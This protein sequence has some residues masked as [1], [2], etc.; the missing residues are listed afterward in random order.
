MCAISVAVSATEQFVNRSL[1]HAKENNEL[2]DDWTDIVQISPKF[3]ST[4]VA[5]TAEG[6]MVYGNVHNSK[7]Y[8]GNDE[9]LSGIDSWNDIVSFDYCIM[10]TEGAIES[11]AIIGA[12]LTNI[13]PHGQ[14]TTKMA[15]AFEISE[16]N[17]ATATAT[18]S[19]NGM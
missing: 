16:E 6:K 11:A 5:L 10:D 13:C 4:S 17:I 8:S 7:F 19:T 1:F 3:Y 12:E 9:W 18:T 15:I 2:S 14:E